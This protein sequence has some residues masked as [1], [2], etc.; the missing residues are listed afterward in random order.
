MSRLSEDMKVPKYALTTV[1]SAAGRMGQ[2]D[3]AFATFAEYKSMFGL[4]HDIHSYNALLAAVA[5]HRTPRVLPILQ[6]LQEMESLNI[7][8]DAD[9]FGYLI[10]VMTESGDLSSLPVALKMMED[11]QIAVKLRTLRRAAYC[12][13]DA[14]RD[15]MLAELKKA[16]GIMASKNRSYSHAHPDNLHHFF[17]VFIDKKISAR[18]EQRSLSG[19]RILR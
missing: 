3:R 2:S 14:G 18:D 19:E 4:E 6:I 13:V 15:D 1:I 7:K 12:A 16:M 9:S 8:P 10:D 17:K 5:R 11:R